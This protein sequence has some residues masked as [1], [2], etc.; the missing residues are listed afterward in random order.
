[1]PAEPWINFEKDVLHLSVDIC[2]S[3]VEAGWSQGLP[4]YWYS[5]YFS[6]RRELCRYF[7]KD[8]IREDIL[9]VKDLAFGGLWNIGSD[10]MGDGV[11][12][13]CLTVHLNIFE[14]VERFTFIDARHGPHDTANLVLEPVESH[15][16][17]A[18]DSAY[19][20]F[21]KN[22]RQEMFDESYLT[23]AD[24]FSGRRPY[25]WFEFG[26]MKRQQQNDD[27]FTTIRPQKAEHR[28]STKEDRDRTLG[29]R[30]EAQEWMM[31]GF[32]PEY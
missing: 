2:N 14:N 3:A 30:P 12:L 25:P 9:K 29:Y 13:T 31:N 1:M 15:H 11:K 6:G 28:F 23:Y 8:K 32:V 10:P 19:Q 4:D 22:Y 18:Q 5:K 24:I 21:I 7:L 16:L 26:I 20:Q 27:S 17:S